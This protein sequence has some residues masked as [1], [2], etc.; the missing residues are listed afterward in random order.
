MFGA[1]FKVARQTAGGDKYEI[2]SPWFP[3]QADNAIFTFYQIQKLL[4]TGDLV[5]EI[6]H[7]NAE[8]L[9]PGS[10]ITS[11][12]VE[13][14]S[15]GVFWTSTPVTGLKELVRCRVHA[16]FASGAGHYG[17]WFRILE[18]TWFNRARADA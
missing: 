1:E 7:K 10:L 6:F 5:V 12:F 8:D 18:P 4:G 9:G 11:T 2:Y 14:G 13:E 3:R 16:G 15:S 17:A